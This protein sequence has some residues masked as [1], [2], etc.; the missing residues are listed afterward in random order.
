MAII[1][2]IFHTPFSDIII[3]L[4]EKTNLPKLFHHKFL[5]NYLILG[6]DKGKRIRG[7]N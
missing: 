5:M 6:N 3:I 1:S 2:S 7:W 4:G